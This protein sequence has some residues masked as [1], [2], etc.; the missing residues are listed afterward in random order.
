MAL[1]AGVDRSRLYPIRGMVVGHT[2]NAGFIAGPGQI[3]RIFL[4]SSIIT[5]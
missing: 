2:Y 5:N 3:G 1:V 4:N